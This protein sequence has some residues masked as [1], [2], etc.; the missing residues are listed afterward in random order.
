MNCP[1]CG[2]QTISLGRWLNGINSIVWT[3]PHCEAPL[4]VSHRVVVA[5]V[6]LTAAFIGV[7][8]AGIYLRLS[9]A[10][11]EAQGDAFVIRG[12]LTVGA[13]SIPVVYLVARSGAYRPR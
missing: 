13:L 9:G 6:L 10:V 5:L 7:A 2:N 12:L 3:C 1:S 4:R 8:A 11:D